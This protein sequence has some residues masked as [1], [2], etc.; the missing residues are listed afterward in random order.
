PNL[1]VTL[2]IQPYPL[3]GISSNSKLRALPRVQHIRPLSGDNVTDSCHYIPGATSLSLR[4]LVLSARLYDG[5][6][7]PQHGSV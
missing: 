4:Q 2:G 5:M 1:G 7:S 3:K 6:H